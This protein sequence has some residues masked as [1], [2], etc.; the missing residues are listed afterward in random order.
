MSDNTIAVEIK[1]LR[2]AYKKYKPLL[3]VNELTI[4]KGEKVFFYGPSGSGKTTL[5]GIIAGILPCHT[6]TIRILGNDFSKCTAKERDKIRGTHMGYIFQ[7]FNLIPYLTV[8]E[9][10]VLPAKLNPKK[11]KQFNAHGLELEAISLAERLGIETILE[12]KVSEISVGQS[13]RVAAA[14]ALLGS[15]SLIIADEPT[16][17]LDQDTG[18]QFIKNLF[19]QCE[20]Q[21]TTLIFVSH[22]KH[23]LPYF[24]KRIS[25][26]EL[27]RV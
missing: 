3:E 23:L 19:E 15:P 13:Q 17:A 1:G 5:L 16:S 7:L 4:F 12:K 18:E 27:N 8:L 21:N 14:R 9:N 6:G 10:I 25:L 2:F 20:I 24:Q 11:G 22:D 26:V